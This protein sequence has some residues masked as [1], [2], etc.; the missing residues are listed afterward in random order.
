MAIAVSGIRLRDEDLTDEDTPQRKINLG[1]GSADTP[2]EKSPEEIEQD[3][4]L[5]KSKR[6]ADQASRDFEDKMTAW[7]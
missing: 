1:K 7:H 5:G 3:K 6:P 2:L 4:V